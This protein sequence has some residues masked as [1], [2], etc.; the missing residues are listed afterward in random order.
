MTKSNKHNELSF[1]CLGYRM[2]PFPFWCVH[3][4][5]FDIWPSTFRSVSH[6]KVIF[7]SSFV[8]E[9]ESNEIKYRNQHDELLTWRRDWCVR[10]FSIVLTCRQRYENQHSCLFSF[11]KVYVDMSVP[12]QNWR[13]L[14]IIEPGD[15]RPYQHLKPWHLSIAFLHLDTAVWN[16]MRRDR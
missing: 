5:G 3:C 6:G 11:I 10:I 14:C 15:G 7:V 2:F 12:V 16:F 1:H 13:A 8:S 9:I 4:A